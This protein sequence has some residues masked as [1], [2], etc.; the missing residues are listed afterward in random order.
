MLFT[1]ILFIIKEI[2]SGSVYSCV[3]EVEP[4]LS[5]LFMLLGIEENSIALTKI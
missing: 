1:F 3:T 2:I 4:I 5:Y